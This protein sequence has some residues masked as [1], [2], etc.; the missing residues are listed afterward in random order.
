MDL[1]KEMPQLSFHN[2]FDIVVKDIKTG[3]EK[4]YKAFNIVLNT[5]PV[6]AAS[7]QVTQNIA[8]GSGM[9][10]LGVDGTTLFTYVGNK[11][12]TQI[13]DNW[14]YNQK[15]YWK[16]RSITILPAEHIGVTFT[17]VGLGNGP[18]SLYTH[19]FIEDSE[20]NP[21][22]IG[23][24]TDTQEITFYSTVYWKWLDSGAFTPV[25]G[26]PTRATNVRSRAT[27]MFQLN[28]WYA[29]ETIYATPGNARRPTDGSDD[30]HLYHVGT[31]AGKSL[32][33]GTALDGNRSFGIGKFLT[34]DSNFEIYELGISATSGGSWFYDRSLGRILVRDL[35][36]SIWAGSQ[37]TDEEIG[38]GDGVTTGFNL[39][40]NFPEDAV[41][42]VN[43]TTKTEGTDY[44]IRPLKKDALFDFAKSTAWPNVIDI[45]KISSPGRIFDGITNAYATASN[46]HAEGTDYEAGFTVDLGENRKWGLGEMQVYYPSSGQFYRWDKVD[47][48]V[49]PDNST[50]TKIVDHQNWYRG[51]S[52]PGWDVIPFDIVPT[53]TYRYIKIIGKGRQ[54]FS[55]AP[56]INEIRFKVTLDQIDFTTAPA[57]GNAV[58]ASYLIREHIPKDTFHELEIGGLVFDF[59]YQNPV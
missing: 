8:Y 57:S 46:T 55:N 44:E 12:S 28:G 40:W 35:P 1:R 16:K 6:Q 53:T 59:G 26:D 54:Q 2:N 7:G 29:N 30:Q 27:L 14:D 43:G 22:S 23:P 34:A 38:T 25:F 11:A 56:R 41:V 24:K 17:E 52:T 45:D 31:S 21:I 13:E 37:K 36:V 20:G 19:A 51:A 58:T 9:G 50:F 32:G 48:F 3:E 49:S 47:I 4:K 39:P 15:I 10:T 18:T 5:F 42:K 33:N